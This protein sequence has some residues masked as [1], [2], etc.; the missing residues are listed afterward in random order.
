M[1][2]ERGFMTVFLLVCVALPTLAAEPSAVP[3]RQSESGPSPTATAAKPVP[4][5][6]D[7][8]ELEAT[9]VTGN[10][11]LPKVMVVVPWKHA[12]VGDVSG[13]PSNSLMDEVLKP[14]DRD[15]LRRELDYY[16]KIDSATSLSPA[17]PEN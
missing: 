4:K 6:L 2:S 16:G 3:T 9:E 13:R 8:L 7:R 11:E 17:K 15:V 12:D 10:R 1:R 5:A 14:L